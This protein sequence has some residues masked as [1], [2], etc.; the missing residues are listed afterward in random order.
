[1]AFLALAKK[2]TGRCHSASP[3]LDLSV[4]LGRRSG[5]YSSSHGCGD[6]VPAGAGCCDST[7]PAGLLREPRGQAA[8]EIIIAVMV[9]SFFTFALTDWGVFFLRL[10][11]MAHLAY[12]TSQRVEIDGYL[13]AAEEQKLRNDLARIGCNNPEFS[14]GTRRESQGDAPLTRG[15]DL[16]VAFGCTRGPMFGAG[17]LVGATPPNPA[18][19][20]WVGGRVVSGR[21]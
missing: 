13:S 5:G 8:V 11:P 1:M 16:E 19:K 6:E 21:P 9:M 15:A 7:V 17:A 10:Q 2:R 14:A 4:H 20:M 12:R 18:G 3:D